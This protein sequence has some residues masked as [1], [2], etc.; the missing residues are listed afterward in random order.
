[1]STY[2]LNKPRKLYRNELVE[3]KYLIPNDGEC[4]IICQED[5]NR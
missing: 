2:Q 4:A 3:W 5:Y 1:M